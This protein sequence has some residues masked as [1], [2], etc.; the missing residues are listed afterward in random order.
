MVETFSKNTKRSVLE[1]F[2]FFLNVD[3]NIYLNVVN[4]FAACLR[5][6]KFLTGKIFILHF[7]KRQ[8]HHRLVYRRHIQND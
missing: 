5:Q 4:E 1:V 3:I 2:I 8:E 7:K 6:S